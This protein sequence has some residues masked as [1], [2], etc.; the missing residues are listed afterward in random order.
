LSNTVL[1]KDIN[2]LNV[3][4]LSQNTLY[5]IDIT[6]VGINGNANLTV[7]SNTSMTA[8]DIV[9]PDTKPPGSVTRLK[10]VSYAQNYINWTWI[11]P[12]D[13]DF[14]NTIVNMT[15]GITTN[16][17]N[18]VLPKDKNYLNVTGLSPNTLYEIDI[19]TVDVSGNVNLT[20]VSNVS[21]TANVSVLVSN[22]SSNTLR[23]ITIGDVHIGGAGNGA[24][25]LT[26]AVNLINNMTDVDFIVELG[27]IVDSNSVANYD[28]AQSIISKSNKPFYLVDGNHDGMSSIYSSCG[29][30]YPLSNFGSRFGRPDRIIPVKDYQLV[31][32]GICA[33][34]SNGTWKFPSGANYNTQTLI[35]NHGPVQPKSS[36]VPCD[37]WGGNNYG[38]ACNMKSETDKF[39]NLLGFYA[40]HVHK[41]TQWLPGDGTLYITE[42][43][44]GGISNSLYVGDTKIDNGKVTYSRLKY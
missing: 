32:V 40:G 8:R 33:L 5:E 6:T 17:F 31:F 15:G 1:P 41:W 10:N 39:T 29:S 21:K 12:T 37:Q 19:Y 18:A 44:L 42:D 7:V 9:P 24:A 36:S 20:L 27:D 11:N 28:V 38:Y 4:G 16:L 30:Y 23:F 35:F 22:V 2:Y 34:S 13:A 3:T 43:G 14:N 26:R 25:N